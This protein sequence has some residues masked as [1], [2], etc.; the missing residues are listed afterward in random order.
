VP[1]QQWTQ[2]D[3]E[4]LLRTTGFHRR[5]LVQTLEGLRDRD[6]E[7]CEV[8]EDAGEDNRFLWRRRCADLAAAEAWLASDHYRT[9]LGAIKVLGTLEA[10]RMCGLRGIDE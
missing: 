5:E 8:F 6:R 3:V 4:V 10:V 2:F 1:T 9:L 7:S